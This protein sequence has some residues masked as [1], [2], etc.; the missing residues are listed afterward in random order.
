MKEGNRKRE[1]YYKG[2]F[3]TAAIY[4]F[5]LGIAFL[6][7]YKFLFA[8]FNI[9]L[10]ENPAYLSL[11]AAF[12]FVIGI[13]YYLIYKNIHANR[14]LAKLGAIYKLAYAAIAFYYF[15]LGLVPHFIF[16][17]LG[18]IDLAFMFLFIEFL[19]HTKK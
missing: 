9:A 17:I 2:L 14:D 6:F 8:L 5:I 7:F 19:N 18:I 1:G 15:F 16:A 4:D 11:S 3:L 10:P 12:V 13:G